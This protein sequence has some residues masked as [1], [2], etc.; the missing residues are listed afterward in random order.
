MEDLPDGR[1]AH[2]QQEKDK[3]DDPVV[4][5]TGKQCPLTKVNLTQPFKGQHS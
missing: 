3:R 4:T 1:T 5:F 2:A